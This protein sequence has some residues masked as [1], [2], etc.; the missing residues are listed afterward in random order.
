MYFPTGF[1]YEKD[2]FLSYAGSC[3]ALI[4]L[5]EAMPPVTNAPPPVSRRDEQP[6]A[7]VRTAL[8]GTS[9]ELKILLDRGLDPNSRTSRGTTVLM[10]AAT[11]ADKVNLLLSRGA[12]PKVRASSNVDA[13]ALA[14]ASRNTSAAIQALLDAGAEAN[15][16]DGVRLKNPPLLLAAM[17]GDI[18]NVKTLLAHGARSSDALAQAVTFGYPDVVRTLIDAGASAT[19]TESSGI[20]LLHW[21]AIANRAAVIPALVAAG[22]PINAKD[23]NGYTPLMYAAT[24][25]FGKTSSLDALLKA[26]ADPNIRNADGRTA[27][28]QAHWLRHANLESALKSFQRR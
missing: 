26:G 15:P 10:M 8:F 20:N 13:L 1:P 12:D 14:A 24:I 9:E 11:D 25:D 16:P 18:E 27:L 4:A 3:W 7:W 5:I 2:E 17:T 21:A 19:M 23:E 22:V 28:E 6:A